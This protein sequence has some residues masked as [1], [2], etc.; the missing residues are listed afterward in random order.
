MPLGR[1]SELTGMSPNPD[2]LCGPPAPCMS[3]LPVPRLVV[4]LLGFVRD[5]QLLVPAGDRIGATRID[6]GDRG[7]GSI[8]WRGM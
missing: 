7:H 6:A 3:H 8:E 5:E 2:P 1:A 4:L